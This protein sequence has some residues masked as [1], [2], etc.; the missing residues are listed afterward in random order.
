METLKNLSVAAAGAAV[1]AL[2]TVFTAQASTIT[3][4]SASLGPTKQFGGIVLDAN[5]FLGW[6]FQLNS[7]FQVTEIGGHLSGSFFSRGNNQ[8]FGAIV[9]LSA[10]NALPQG[11]PFQPGEVVA[12]TTFTPSFPSSD[13]TVPLSVTL[14]PGN[15][16]L[17]FGSG[18][19]GASGEGF[20]PYN[21]TNLSDPQS[22]IRWPATILGIPASVPWINEGGSPFR[23]VVQGESDTSTSVPETTPTLGILAFGALGASSLLK[24]RRKSVSSMVSN[25]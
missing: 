4:E 5:Q 21:N 18:L 25:V 10:P 22:Y 8:I 14:N 11:D 7:T 20:M 23:F 9:S 6:R 19:F 13:V 16:A 15:Y 3:L 17:I 1:L 24:R 2:G 12:S